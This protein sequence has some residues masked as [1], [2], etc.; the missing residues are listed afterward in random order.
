MAALNSTDMGKG[1]I[2]CLVTNDLNQDQRMARICRS[3]KKSGFDV[4][5][6][7]REK[8]NSKPLL[9]RDF[10]QKRLR[11]FFNKSF[12]FYAEYN[13]RLFLFLIRQSYTYTYSADLDTVLPA[14]LLRVLRKKKF[15]F[16][17]HEWFS[18]TPELENRTFVKK[19]W[20]FIGSCCVPS[21]S[22]ALTVNKS[23]SEIFSRQY[24]IPFTAV[25]NAPVS[26]LTKEED[27]VQK[28]PY[29]IIYQGVLNEGRGLEQLIA[30]MEYI[31]E[32]RLVIVGEGDLSEH[33]RN[34]ASTSPAADRIAFTG[35]L[36]GKE[37][38]N[39][40][41]SAWLGVNILE[42]KS[43]NYYYSLANKFFDYVHAGIPAI[44]MSFPEYEAILREYPVGLTI[45]EPDVKELVRVIKS[46]MENPGQYDKMV[47]ACRE[48]KKIY[49]WQQEEKKLVLALEQS[50]LI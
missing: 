17:A 5:L 8:K 23:L 32:A 11:C 41:E 12:L 15:I 35:W 28:A 45:K 16:D 46:L 26:D 3:L 6:V 42:G 14:Y 9:A 22:L 36:F 20:G 49:T 10:E 27:S 31:P 21:A 7:G 19:V 29:R 4:F 40:T 38:Q 47:K 50:G 48:A 44:H 30:A 43:K 34:L 37:L 33:V 24:G 39:S 25:Y 2:I 18:E 1:K 13:L